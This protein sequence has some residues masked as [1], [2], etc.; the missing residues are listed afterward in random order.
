MRTPLGRN[1]RWWLAGQL[2]V[3]VG[4]FAMGWY[5]G[6]QTAPGGNMAGEKTA[7]SSQ[8]SAKPQSKP[9]VISEAQAK[10]DL[11]QMFKAA[12]DRDDFDRIQDY[13]ET[14]G[15]DTIKAFLDDPDP[16]A[17]ALRDQMNLGVFIS[18]WAELNPN[19][20][21]DW[22]LSH[23]LAHKDSVIRDVFNKWP[24][25]DPASFAALNQVKGRLHDEIFR[26]LID[27]YASQDPA[28]AF[29]VLSK[30]PLSQAYSSYPT[31]FKWWAEHD[32]AA[33][34]AAALNLPPSG[35]RDSTLETIA[36]TWAD[37]NPT[38][39]KAWVDSLPAGPSKDKA[40]AQVVMALSSANP[41]AIAFS[42]ADY[43]IPP[44][45][46]RD[47]MIGVIA[48]DFAAKDPAGALAWAAG[49]LTG[50]DFETASVVAL[51][52]IDDVDPATAAAYLAKI[53]DPAVIDRALPMI[54]SNWGRQDPQAAL[55]WAQALPADNATERNSAISSVMST[56]TPFDPAA[57]GNYVLQ[58][59]TADPS[60]VTL[61]T[62]VATSW[63][64]VDPQGAFNWALSL[65][66]G[67]G[68]RIN[69]ITTALGA[70]ADVDPQAAWQ[71]AQKLTGNNATRAEASVIS[72]W[73]NQQ[74]GQAAVA[75]QNLPPGSNL[76][77]AT[78]NV[79][80]SWLTQDP[81]AASQWI[82]TLPQG[83]ARDGAVTQIIA[84]VG[85]NDPAAAFNWAVSIGNETTRDAQVVKLA[86]QWS[87]QNPAAAASAIQ[88]ALGNLSG[89]TADQQASLQKLAAKAPVP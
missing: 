3:M 74:P 15:A 70:L 26:N 59:L 52:Q 2:V 83:S 66:T 14:L 31:V 65:P 38:A 43:N 20:A 47:E 84:T 7:K 77:T 34:V 51:R 54:L 45:A 58:N 53:P 80:K 85:K 55:A 12:K 28:G 13:I 81:N 86:T 19:A 63:S 18:R 1:K 16:A 5:S 49:K 25:N 46:A 79:A 71:D 78:A 60:F 50:K 6:K 67:G 40:L 4:V 22:T 87:K 88:N 24:M 73:A 17:Q 82:D 10:A 21:L 89:L 32:P 37:S 41:S 62:Q 33:A 27:L 23:D 68:A 30:E 8:S 56:W 36:G 75:L 39:A 61:A 29:A 42:L 11:A 76:D 9:V 69:S 64:N 72:A 44:G 57:A 48:L 35:M